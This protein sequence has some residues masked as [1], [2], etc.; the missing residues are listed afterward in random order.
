MNLRSFI[1][2]IVVIIIVL[3]VIL[4]AVFYYIESQKQKNIQS[5]VVEQKMW[6]AYVGD[7]TNDLQNFE[8]EVGKKLNIQAT[9]ISWGNEN[10]FPSTTQNFKNKTLLI[11]WEAQDYN[12]PSPEQPKFSYKSILNGAWDSYIKSFAEQAKN[13]GGPVILIPFDEMNINEYT[14]SGQ[15]NGNNPADFAK[16]Y[17]HVHDLFSTA[18]NVK[19][20]WAVNNDSVPDTTAN[21]ITAYYPGDAYVDYVGVD[22]FNFGDP[23]QTYSEVFSSALNTLSQ[24]NKPI[25]IFSM[26]CAAGTQKAS[27]I[28]DALS[29]I[30]S[31]SRIKGW[32]WFN[33]NKEENWLVNSDANSLKA[34]QTGVK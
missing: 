29:K 11:F 30:Y 16:V 12:D 10:Q 25:Y 5:P 33:E 15:A 23:W 17:Q 27:W 8:N 31:D 7:N 1:K 2:I 26:A 6:G 28:A 3:A 32:I 4:T 9:F 20:G 13:Y 19:F 21:A 34:F 18:T 24:Y 22:G 14:W